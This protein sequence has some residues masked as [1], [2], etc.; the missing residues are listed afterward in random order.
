MLL[1]CECGFNYTA[2]II[3]CHDLHIHVDSVILEL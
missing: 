1:M 2:I 3:E